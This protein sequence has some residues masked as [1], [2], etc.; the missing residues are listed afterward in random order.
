LPERVGQKP[1][2]KSVRARVLTPGLDRFHKRGRIGKSIQAIGKAFT[3][4]L[5]ARDWHKDEYDGFHSLDQMQCD[6][7]EVDQFDANERRDQPTDAVDQKIA[8]QNLGRTNRAIF[9]AGERQ[10]N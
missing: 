2:P 10:R 6:Q 4:I 7:H 8:N 1:S 5:N 9:Y 3:E